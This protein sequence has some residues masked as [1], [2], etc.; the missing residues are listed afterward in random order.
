VPTIDVSLEFE[1]LTQIIRP[2]AEQSAGVVDVTGNAATALFPSPLR[3]FSPTSREAIVAL[4]RHAKLRF[5]Q[6]AY[7]APEP[8]DLARIT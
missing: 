7:R 6:T 5:A 2:A 1:I 8:S 3:N 4:L